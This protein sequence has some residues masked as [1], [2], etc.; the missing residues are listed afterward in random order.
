MFQT[1]VRSLQTTTTDGAG[2]DSQALAQAL[3]EKVK[4]LFVQNFKNF[5]IT[6]SADFCYLFIKV[7]ALLL[8]SQEEERYL[9]ERNLHVALQRKVEELQ[10]NLLQ[11]IFSFSWH[12]GLTWLILKLIQILSYQCYVLFLTN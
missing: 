1:D 4:L 11:V 10:R 3:Q 5:E 9:L 2:D 8:L 7:S 12:M 6:V